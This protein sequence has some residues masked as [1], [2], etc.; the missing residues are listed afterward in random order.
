MS[1]PSAPAQADAIVVGGGPRRASSPRPS[2]PPPASGSILVDQEPEQ[3]LGGQAFWSFGGLFLV[4]SAE[5]RRLRIK[6][7]RE[8]AWQDWL[9]HRRLRPRPRTSGRGAGPRRTSTWP[10][11]RSARGCTRRASASSRRR[12][13]RAR[14]RARRRARQLRPPLPRH[15]GHRPRA[16]RAVRRGACARAQRDGLVELAL[17]PPR[18]P[19]HRTNGAVDGVARRG[20]R[21][22]RVRARAVELARRRRRVRAERARR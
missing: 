8:L 17:P 10:P 14:R 9:R 12:L 18:R 22:R 13:G 1:T 7:S 4:D 16:R 20:A 3:S 2:S 5:Q 11:A 6:D 19:A 15:L 21:A